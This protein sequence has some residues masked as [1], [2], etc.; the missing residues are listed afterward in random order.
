MGR[1]VFLSFL[2]NGFYEGTRYVESS[3]EESSEQPLRFIQ[4]ASINKFC[5]DYSTDDYIYIFTT[6]GALVN[7]EDGE[8]S[9]SRAN[10]LIYYEG[11]NS[12]LNNLNLTCSFQNIMIPDGKS[13]EEIWEIFEVVFNSIQVGDEITFDITHGFRS[14]PMLNMVL[15]NYAKLL[16]NIKVD[17]IYYGAYEARYTTNNHEYSPIWNLKDFEILQEWTN[18]ANIFLT[19]GNASPLVS[20][21]KGHESVFDLGQ[22]LDKFSKLVLVNRGQDILEG[23][24][25]VA[26]QNG[27]D[28]YLITSNTRIPA[29]FPILAKIKDEF[30][31]Y[32]QDSVWNGFIAVKWCIQNGLIQQAATMLEEFIITYVLFEL[33]QEFYLKNYIIRT[34]VS[35]AL[36]I[37]KEQKFQYLTNTDNNTGKQALKEWQ[38]TN[39]TKIRE[40]PYKK[41]LGKI[42]NDLKKSIR[43]DINHA[44]FRE[45]PSEFNELQKSI[46]KRYNELKNL[47][48]Q[49]H[50]DRNLPKL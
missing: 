38:I 47:L 46:S 31:D 34:T 48:S 41:K 16:K 33:G 37:G 15:I 17:G 20:L 35:A 22:N 29:L 26:F 32:R 13:T 9:N 49:L 6:T 28:S 44:G 1:K 23:S 19:T 18:Q 45:T 5:S 42:L 3:S 30:K 7:W 8:H 40:Q 14:L 39:V 2:G 21:F 11:L 27:L 4:E 10:K 43:N 12:R 25:M 24:T 50:P 36:T